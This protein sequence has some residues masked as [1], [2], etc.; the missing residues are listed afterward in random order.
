MYDEY[1]F[2]ND[3]ETNVENRN[4]FNYGEYRSD[5]EKD[6]FDRQTKLKYEEMASKSVKRGKK[7]LAIAFFV[8]AAICIVTSVFFYFLNVLDDET[9]EPVWAGLLIIGGVWV[10]VAVIVLIFAKPLSYDKMK[11]TSE[12]YGG[13]ISYDYAA[14]EMKA[15]MEV[16]EN[17]V[18]ELED[19]VAELKNKL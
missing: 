13:F 12:K 17:R 16:L 4:S 14:F 6:D 15:K 1:G 8:M 2:K 18:K 3:G 5:I 7:A 11:K 10:L 19:E 9:G